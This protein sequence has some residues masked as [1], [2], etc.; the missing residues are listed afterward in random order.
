MAPQGTPSRC[1]PGCDTGLQGRRR[2]WEEAGEERGSGSRKAEA[3]SGGHKNY[4]PAAPVALSL[5]ISEQMSLRPQVRSL[6]E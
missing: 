6:Q 2:F 4:S 1:P 5:V 3:V